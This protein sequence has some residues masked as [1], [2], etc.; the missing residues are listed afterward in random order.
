M[1]RRK[2]ASQKRTKKT[3]PRPKTHRSQTQKRKTPSKRPIRVGV[4]AAAGKGTRAWPRTSFIPKPLFL[5]EGKT[6]LERNVD[7]QFQIIGVEKLYIIVGHLQEQVLSEVN[8]IRQLYPERSIET[9]QWTKEGLAADVAGLRDR[10]QEDFCLLLGDEFYHNTNHE[11]LLSLWQKKRNAKAL[12]AIL[13]T[14]FASEIRK[15][16]SVLL[17]EKQ[18]ILE[19]IEKPRNP[20][21]NLLGLG[22][23]VFTPDYFS[24]FDRTPASPRSGVIELTDVIQNMAEKSEVCAGLLKGR[25]FNI[26]SLADYYAANYLLRAATFDKNKISLIIPALNNEATIRDVL[27]DFR[28]HVDEILVVDL[29]SQDNTAR[30]VLGKN[31]RLFQEK[32]PDE[33]FH[34][35][36]A[37][38]IFAAMRQAKG[39]ILVLATA[40]GSFRAGDLPKLLE[41]VKDADMA[42]GTRTTRQMIE[43]GSNLSPMYRWLNVF[44]GKLVEIFWWSQEPRF[45]DIGCLYRAIWKESFL[46]IADELEAKNKVYSLEMMVELM[47]HHMRC[48]EIPISYYKHY[49]FVEEDSLANKWRYFWAVLRLILRKRFLG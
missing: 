29:G 8:R 30:L 2:A 47:R 28:P 32:A 24:F 36:Y 16:Y 6:L 39:E 48:I 27:E 1:A 38:P 25:Y 44:F 41:Y 7:I 45:T 3:I 10:I 31:T 21:N 13:P 37:P 17:D 34:V 42:V 40:D 35:H 46:K 49:G 19:L 15:N 23:Y 26:N 5:F 33:H 14:P 9:V 43:Q 11:T 18:R 4:I 12:I 22:S 20:P